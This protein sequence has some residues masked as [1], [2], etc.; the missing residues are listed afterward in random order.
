MTN[1]FLLIT[2]MRH[3]NEKGEDLLTADV[4]DF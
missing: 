4:A 1:H 3:D 2:V